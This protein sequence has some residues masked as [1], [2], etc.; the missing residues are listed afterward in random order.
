[1]EEKLNDV[2]FTS[3]IFSVIKSGIEY[4]NITA[5]EKVSKV[6]KIEYDS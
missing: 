1:M 4:D 5:W 6:L 3:D 2:E